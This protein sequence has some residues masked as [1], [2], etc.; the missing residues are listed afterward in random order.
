MKLNMK[1]RF[2]KILYLNK[3]QN[4][5]TLSLIHTHTLSHSYSLHNNKQQHSLELRKL[6][7]SQRHHQVGD[8][9]SPWDTRQSCWCRGLTEC[10]A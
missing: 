7:P 8:P 3:Y 4:Q 5:S 9:R 2:K 6:H 10:L 1:I